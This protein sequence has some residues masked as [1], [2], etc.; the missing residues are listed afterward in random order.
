MSENIEKT[1]TVSAPARLNLS[2]IRG[3]V[4]IRPGQDGEIHVTANKH[5]GSGDASRT[6]VELVQETDGTVK[7]A[8]HFPDA[9]WSW[10]IGSFPC[11][12]DYVVRAPRQCS[13][14]I[15]GVSSDIVAEG[16]EGEF[17]FNSVSGEMTLRKLSG[18][19]NAKTVSGAIELAELTGEMRINTVSGQIS[20]KSLAGGLHLDTISG[21]VSF[22]ESS[23]PSAEA[24]TV[25]GDMALQTDL[26][27]GPYRFNSVSGNV[28][29]KVPPESRCDAELHAISGS[30]S[31]KL[32][33]TSTVRQNGKQ[34]IEVQ[35]GG[36][37]LYLNSVSG[38]LSLVS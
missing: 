31:T 32:P 24:T 16:F 11:R 12:V 8:T 33:A 27:N 18:P 19:V 2:N 36:V 15:N 20:G 3:S 30:L 23:L 35:G 28:E 29:L 1:F 34:T 26:G 14:K 7:V 9:G 5:S 13:L 4:E 17:N 6:D 22:Q 37:K 10:L 25:S 38:N 21:R